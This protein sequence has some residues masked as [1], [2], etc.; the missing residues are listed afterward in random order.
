MSET[1]PAEPVLA[2][3]VRDFLYDAAERLELSGGVR[4]WL[5]AADREL[6]V[7]VPVLGDDGVLRVF[8]GYRVQHSNVLGPYKGGL[9]FDDEVSLPE[10]RALAQL[11]TLKC[12][13]ADLPL[14]GG[15]GGVACPAKELSPAELERLARALARALAPNLGAD[16]DVMAPDMNVGEQTMAWIADE[17]AGSGARPYEPGVVTG[18][19]IPLGGSP[20]RDAATGR[21]VVIAYELLRERAGLEPGETRVAIQGTGNVG[22]WAAKLFTELGCRVVAMSK[23]DGTAIN[24]DGLD[25]G[26]LAEH[27]EDAGAI[28]G[29][30]GGERAG[31]DAI[32]DVDCEVFVPAARAGMLDVDGAGRLSARMVVEGANG[33][34]TPEAERALRDTGSLVVPDLLANTGG[35]VVSYF[36]WLQNRRRERWSEATVDERLRETLAAGL[37]AAVQRAERDG[38]SLRAAGYDIAIERVLE[39]ARLRR[40]L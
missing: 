26:A 28:E 27:L 30:G 9:R 32:L 24:E 31:P 29:F 10:T 4:D 16:V 35:V 40:L 1:I 19:S 22:M 13:A 8:D 5:F 3:S 38:G 39:A 6:H 33:P 36:E 11:M 15:K 23:S 18:K 25:P 12:A 20:G 37:R 14:G 34:L 7:K 21:G 17:L 2:R